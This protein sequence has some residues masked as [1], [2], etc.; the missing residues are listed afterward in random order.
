MWCVWSYCEHCIPFLPLPSLCSLSQHCWFS[1]C[2]FVAGLCHCGIAVM[3]CVWR[4]GVGC[5]LSTVSSYVLWCVFQCGVRVVL[6]YCVVEW[7]G[8]ERVC[9]LVACFPLLSVFLFLFFFFV[10][11]FGVVR[12]QLCE[13]ARYPR[14][15]LCFSCCV[16]FSAPRLSSRPAFLC[17]EWRW[18][19]TMCHCVVW[20]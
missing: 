9:G 12:A 6:L 7:R 17:L 19:F 18:G 3:V 13:H 2:V 14:T 1:C 11:V 8:G 16:L 4:K 15:P 10:L 20:A 5:L